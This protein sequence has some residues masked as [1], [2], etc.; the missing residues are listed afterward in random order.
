[1]MKR[2]LLALASSMALLGCGSS[3]DNGGPV[4]YTVD[5]G[6]QRVPVGTGIDIGPFSVPNGTVF[7]YSITDSPSGVGA[8]SLQASILPGGYASLQGA[9][10]SGTTPQLPAGSYYFDVYCNN[11]VDDCFFS[12]LVTATY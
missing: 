4:V 6:N 2:A 9:S 10:F 12:D 5:S 7:T 8:D 3:T 11:I 1:M